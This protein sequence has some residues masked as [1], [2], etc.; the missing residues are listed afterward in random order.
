[1]SGCETQANPELR[2]RVR[3]ECHGKLCV[4]RNGRLHKTRVFT[5]VPGFSPNHN[6]GVYNNSVNSVERAFIERYFLCKVG[7]D[8][9]PAL[10]SSDGAF[11][12]KWLKQF[13]VRC[14]SNMPHLP[15]LTLTQAVSLFPAQKRKVYEKALD[16][17]ASKGDVT[18]KDAQLSSFVKFEKQDVSKAP[19]VINPRSPRYNLKLATYLK[20]FEH[21]MFKAINK[22]FGGR[23]KATVIKGF[24]ADESG[25]IFKDKWMQF[26][27]PVAVGLDATKFD[28]H[29]SR[30]ALI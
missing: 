28:M 23:T 5:V 1:V 21:H 19:R 20:H 29:V 16:T 22:T 9:E 30:F 12:T 27:N 4:R 13:R 26:S 24:D 14:L 8:F 15:R 18:E 3:R 17:F 7:P 10:Q 25:E 11:R 6:L 2:E